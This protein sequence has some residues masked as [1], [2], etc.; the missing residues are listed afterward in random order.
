[1]ADHTPLVA[2]AQH[3]TCM[4][5]IFCAC[6][7]SELYVCRSVAQF[8]WC[9]HMLLVVDSSM[10]PAALLAYMFKFSLLYATALLVY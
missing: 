7:V 3:A 4:L 2:A 10:V 8:M 6:I 5:W 1:M 9:L